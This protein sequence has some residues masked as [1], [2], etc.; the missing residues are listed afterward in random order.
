MR[1]FYALVI[2][3]TGAAALADTLYLKDGKV[4]GGTYL[5]GTARQVRMDLGDRVASYDLAD[6]TKIEFQSVSAA[7]PEPPPPPREEPRARQEPRER[8]RVHRADPDSTP[9]S[10]LM[11]P[12]GTA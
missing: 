1:Y 12:S 7:V 8:P 11:T 10:S 5:G 2:L 3:A 4:V 9:S 6:V